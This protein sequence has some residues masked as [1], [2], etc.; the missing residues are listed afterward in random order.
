[1]NLFDVLGERAGL[2]RSFLPTDGRPNEPQ[3][4]LLSYSLWQRRFGG[5]SAIIGRDILINSVPRTVIGIMRDGMRFPDAPVG[6][7]SAR[8]DL[9]IA[10]TYE[11]TRALN[12]RGNQNLVI[13]GRRTP[14][15]T[16]AEIARDIEATKARFKREFP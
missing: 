4:A 7:A 16:S 9:W 11:T 1:P 8:A 13:L 15:A 6:Y 3:V 5:D 12:Q 14:T 10:N 2:G